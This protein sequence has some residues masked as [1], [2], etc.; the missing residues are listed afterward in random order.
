MQNQVSPAV[1]SRAYKSV[2]FTSRLIVAFCTILVTVSLSFMSYTSSQRNTDE[3]V[4]IRAGEVTTLIAKQSGGALKFGKTDF[5]DGLFTYAFDGADGA[6]TSGSV[7]LAGGEIL[8]THGDASA[9]GDGLDLLVQQALRTGEPVRSADGFT[10]V[11]PVRFG[12]DD[13]I[14]GAV[15]MHWTSALLKAKQFQDH[16]FAILV[17]GGLGLAG[18]VGAAI[19]PLCQRSCPPLY[20]SSISQVG[21]IGR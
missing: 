3:G 7:F 21:G 15:A 2:F 4:R 9:F 20:F 10:A 18:L 5:F 13:T 12:K 16:L 8:S 11:S 17:A 1:Q 14:V 6:A 19:F